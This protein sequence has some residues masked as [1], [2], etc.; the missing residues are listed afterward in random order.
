MIQQFAYWL[1]WI[2]LIVPT[3]ALLLHWLAHHHEYQ[4][5][6]ARR[7]EMISQ[8]ILYHNPHRPGTAE[9]YN[10]ERYWQHEGQHTARAHNDRIKQKLIQNSKDETKNLRHSLPHPDRDPAAL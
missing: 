5:Q 4:E 6:R 9:W 7:A 10:Y 2:V 1:G 3:S 8:L